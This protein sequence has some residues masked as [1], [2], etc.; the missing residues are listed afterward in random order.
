MLLPQKYQSIHCFCQM[1]TVPGDKL[2]LVCYRT[3]KPWSPYRCPLH[4]AQGLEQLW[5]KRPLPWAQVLLAE[6][7]CFKCLHLGFKLWTRLSPLVLL[8]TEFLYISLATAGPLVS[9][10]MVYVC[11]CPIES[12]S[13]DPPDWI[14]CI[15]GTAKSHKGSKCWSGDDLSSGKSPASTRGPGHL[16][17]PTDL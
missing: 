1:I 8:R 15:A 13:D 2:S 17:S 4:V 14:S 7:V 6:A 16:H 5:G 10:L 3:Y 11:H 12:W 9:P